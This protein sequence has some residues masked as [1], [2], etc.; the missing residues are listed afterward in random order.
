[1]CDENG[2][3]R[4]GKLFVLS[5]G[6]FGDLS[7]SRLK[8]LS[9]RN[10]YELLLQAGHARADIIRMGRQHVRGGVLSLQRQKTK[11]AFSVTVMPMLRPRST[12]R[13]RTTA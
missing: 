7:E 12:P 5:A 2:S 4:T 11:V 6:L 3:D 10:P 8:I 1:M 9:R 13:R